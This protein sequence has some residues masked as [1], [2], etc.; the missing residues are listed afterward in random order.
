MRVFSS[1]GNV[2]TKKRNGLG[3]YTVDAFVFLNGSHG[4]AWPSGISQEI[5]GSKDIFFFFRMAAAVRDVGI[6]RVVVY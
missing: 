4:L 1:A 6:M 5:L 2:V 3:D